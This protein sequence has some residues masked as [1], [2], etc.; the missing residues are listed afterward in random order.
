M[1]KNM[2]IFRAVV[3]VALDL[4]V[5]GYFAAILNSNENNISTYSNLVLLFCVGSCMFPRQEIKSEDKVSK[6]LIIVS[7]IFAG[8][9][10]GAM[11]VKLLK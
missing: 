10:L 1:G 9:Y 8:A 7:Y 6:A 4:A 2:K 11:V 3:L 5:I